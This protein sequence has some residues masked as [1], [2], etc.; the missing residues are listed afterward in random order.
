VPIVPTSVHVEIG[1]HESGLALGQ[2]RDAIPY[3]RPPPDYPPHAAAQGTQGWVR[4]QFSITAAGTVRDAR[5][6]DANPKDTFE[7]AALKGI[8]RWRYNPKVEG[9]V[10]VE[11]VGLQT[12]L[13]FELQ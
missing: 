7:D 11:S 13:R 4:V 8:A 12:I 10:A 1:G 5:V 9:G 2:D 6:V 3:F